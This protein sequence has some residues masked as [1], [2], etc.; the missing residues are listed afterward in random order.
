[1]S[2]DP[3]KWSAYRYV[4]RSGELEFEKLFAFPGPLSTF[5]AGARRGSVCVI[6]GGM[7]GLTAA[8]EL[9]QLQYEVTVLEGSSRWGG[10]IFTHYFR[11]DTYGEIGAMR[12]PITHKCVWHY[13]DHIFG[14]GY[15]LGSRTLVSSNDAGWLLFR[16]VERRMGDHNAIGAPL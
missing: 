8:Y 12:I 14:L 4:D 1:M 3:W 6:G 11:D 15:R 5:D 13:I 9:L 2:Q 7:A 10:R 16:G